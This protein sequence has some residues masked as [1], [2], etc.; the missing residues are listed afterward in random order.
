MILGQVVGTVWATRKNPNL[1]RL[2]LAIVRPHFWYN[3]PHDVDHLVA[4]DQVG[5]ERGQDVLVCVGQPGRWMAGTSA[6]PIEA[7]IMAIVDRVV[8]GPSTE[9]GTP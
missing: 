8:M 5:A 3:P 4:V 1:E 2:K 7:S 6:A 9:D